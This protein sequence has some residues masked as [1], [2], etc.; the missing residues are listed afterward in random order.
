MLERK[1]QVW[2]RRSAA[3]GDTPA[4]TGL[5]RV[6]F[7]GLC[8]SILLGLALFFTGC[9]RVSFFPVRG[10]SEGE[11]D[12]R[13][14]GSVDGGGL[15]VSDA[16]D[17]GANPPDSRTHLL[18]SGTIP[19][20]SGTNPTDSGTT[21]A[22]SGA[23]DTGAGTD[24]GTVTDDNDRDGWT[25]DD[26]ISCG[27]NPNSASSVPG[28]VD[29]DGVCDALDTVED[30]SAWGGVLT[31]TVNAQNLGI[32]GNVTNYPLLI[33][34]A[35]NNF[36]DIATRTKSGGADLRFAKPDGTH[37]PYEI[38]DWTDNNSGTVWVL[39]DTVS[40]SAATIIRMY[41]DN[42][43]ASSQ[44]SSESVFNTAHGFEGV[45]HLNEAATDEQNSATHYDATAN[46]NDGAQRGN[47]R[48]TSLMANGQRFD[49]LDDII[50]AGSGSSL[51][52]TDA[53]SLTAW[54][55]MDREPADD[56]WYAVIG[57]QAPDPI[58]S[59]YIFNHL[60]RTNR[61]CV[62]FLLASGRA[63]LWNS[64]QR[65]SVPVGVWAYVAITY[66]GATFRFY[67][68]AIADGSRGRSGPIVDSSGV[69]VFIGGDVETFFLGTLDE[70]RII[71]AVLSHDWL[72]LDYETQRQSQTI[73][74]F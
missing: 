53:I 34:L 35:R 47:A 8:L 66:D 70:A 74:V 38:E 59:M 27:T 37:L 21:P 49:G 52:I 65:E 12:G 73:V 4:P 28:D 57:K 67:M 30:Y 36:G 9:F 50:N 24:T 44:S 45:W 1:E 23:N 29:R 33:R 62:D 31:I 6:L 48:A 60:E 46:N 72:R 7:A 5:P 16:F 10:E 51:N 17:G 42:P 64:G 19:A 14:P 32:S 58:Y 18:D 3:V 43:D 69:D 13:I 20:D 71:N 39:V 22:D 41:Y 68:N 56:E 26:E 25:N 63:D 61:V 40:R 15:A 54:V 55:S 11:S 2:L